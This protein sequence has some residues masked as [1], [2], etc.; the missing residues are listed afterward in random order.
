MPCLVHSR[1]ELPPPTSHPP[2]HTHT[3]HPPPTSHPHPPTP[4]PTTHHPPPT[5]T[6]THTPHPHPPPTHTPTPHR[7]HR[8]CPYLCRR[9]LQQSA[10]CKGCRRGSAWQL[11]R[12]ASPRGLAC[13]LLPHA[14]TRRSFTYPTLPCPARLPAELIRIIINSITLVNTPGT[15]RRALLGTATS[16]A[17]DY[18][19]GWVGGWAGWMGG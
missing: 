18:T 12:L 13:L 14:P 6:H 5:H 3:H 4:T 11:A 9:G 17:I 2:T 7:V 1:S 8:A 10:R 16:V 19:G 15:R